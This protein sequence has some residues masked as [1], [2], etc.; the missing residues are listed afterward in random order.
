MFYSAH[1]AGPCAFYPMTDSWTDQQPYA[2][3]VVLIGDAAG[4]NDPII[5]QGLA[6]ALRDVRIVTDVLRSGPDWS[7]AA[8][9]GYGEERGERMRRLRVAAAVTTDLRTTF[10]PAGASRRRAY[11]AAWQTD[12]LLGGVRLVQLMGPDNVPAGAFSQHAIDRILALV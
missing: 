5:G 10:T 11:N 6:I 8:F 7:A 9:A 3:G 1:S 2:P 4:W 12:P